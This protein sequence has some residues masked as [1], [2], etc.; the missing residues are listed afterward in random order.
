MS[1]LWT[2]LPFDVWSSGI[3]SL[4][5]F[6]E[7][8]RLRQT[9]AHLPVSLARALAER[10]RGTVAEYGI[11]ADAAEDA[12]LDAAVAASG[13]D[14]AAGALVAATNAL[15]RRVLRPC[16]EF[17]RQWKREPNNGEPWCYRIFGDDGVITLLSSKKGLRALPP[18]V[19]DMIRHFEMP[20]WP[21]DNDGPVRLAISYI[22]PAPGRICACAGM[23]TIRRSISFNS[24]RRTFPRPR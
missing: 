6:Q 3:L 8:P 24:W 1:P 10:M 4:L 5:P 20:I 15:V 13:V 21:N 12:A 14:A 9:H 18:F 16:G 19:V 23:T 7:W 11:A 17:T 2:R 22:T